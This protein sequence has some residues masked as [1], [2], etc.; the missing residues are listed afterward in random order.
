MNC[1]SKF[2]IIY[3]PENH[4][5]ISIQ[6]VL[7]IFRWVRVTNWREKHTTRFSSRRNLENFMNQSTIASIDGWDGAFFRSEF[8]LKLLLNHHLITSKY[9]IFFGE[10]DD[11]HYGLT[12]FHIFWLL[13]GLAGP[14]QKW[15]NILHNFSILTHS[16]NQISTKLAGVFEFDR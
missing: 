11:Q 15:L 8:Q 14:H 16:I 12:K 7:L 4:R 2:R 3:A 1:N 6:F 5:I 10:F 13:F 9:S